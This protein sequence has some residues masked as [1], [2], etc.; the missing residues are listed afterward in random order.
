VSGAVSPLTI[1][2]G[3]TIRVRTIGMASTRS[4]HQ[5][6]SVA[7]SVDA[8]VVSGSRTAIPR[9]ADATL[10]VA[11]VE[12]GISLTLAAVTVGGRRYPVSTEAY[13]RESEKT[14]K[15]GVLGHIGGVVHKKHKDSGEAAVIAPESRLTF[16]LRQPVEVM[17]P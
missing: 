6:D 3:T 4:S 8:A 16:T 5:G 7:A 12:D 1:P 10:Q 14:G 11:S 17:A 13:S 15:K 2:A 9:G